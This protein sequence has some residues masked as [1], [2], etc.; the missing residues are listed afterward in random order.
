MAQPVLLLF[1]WTTSSWDVG[2]ALRDPIEC[3]DDEARG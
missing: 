2:A 1:T 3:V